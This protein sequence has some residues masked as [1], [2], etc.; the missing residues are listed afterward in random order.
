MAVRYID[1]PLRLDKGAVFVYDADVVKEEIER[2][3]ITEKGEVLDEPDYGVS[4]KRYLYEPL[5]DSNIPFVE[6]DVRTS[7]NKWM[8][9]RV[10]LNG[11]KVDIDAD[12]YSFIIYLDIYLN[13]FDK[14]LIIG[15]PYATAT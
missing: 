11:V 8:G 6:M 3:L 12:D 5:N 1:F 13:E 7:I 4:L 15:V 10:T 9:D 14:Q 2:L